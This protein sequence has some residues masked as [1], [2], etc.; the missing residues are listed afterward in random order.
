VISMAVML[1]GRPE[2]MGFLLNASNN[3]GIDGTCTLRREWLQAVN[4]T[5]P[6]VFTSWGQ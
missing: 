2:A 4:G 6:L 5:E 3:C 1:C